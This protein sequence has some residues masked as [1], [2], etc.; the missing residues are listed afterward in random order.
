MH[1]S[2]AGQWRTGVFPL[3]TGSSCPF[4]PAYVLVQGDL[5]SSLHVHVAYVLIP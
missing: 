4:I 2:P 5:T 3:Q 1:K